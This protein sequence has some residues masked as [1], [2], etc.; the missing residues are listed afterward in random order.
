MGPVPKAA[1]HYLLCPQGGVL[2][3]RVLHY[4]KLQQKKLNA[5][6]LIIRYLDTLLTEHVCVSESQ[7]FQNIICV[8][9]LVISLRM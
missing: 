5:L 3:V 7:T 2:S 1:V 6:E 4:G 9:T 8:Y